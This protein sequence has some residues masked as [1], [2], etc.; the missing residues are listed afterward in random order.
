MSSLTDRTKVVIIGAGA[1]GVAAA[2]KLDRNRFD[3]LILEA[4]DR[5]GGRIHD[6]QTDEGIGIRSELGL[7]SQPS[8]HSDLDLICIFFYPKAGWN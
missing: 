1:A 5:I 7:K 6:Q 2:S 8:S 4:E 3:V